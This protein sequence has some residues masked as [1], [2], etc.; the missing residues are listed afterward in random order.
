M[1]R[2]SLSRHG[3]VLAGAGP[4]VINESPEAIERTVLLCMDLPIERQWTD[5]DNAPL[6]GWGQYPLMCGA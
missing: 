5:S 6:A 1:T 2:P 3:L 4:I